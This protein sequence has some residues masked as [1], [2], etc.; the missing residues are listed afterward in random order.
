MSPS[1]LQ[2]VLLCIQSPVICLHVCCTLLANMDDYLILGEITVN[3]I[4]LADIVAKYL[5][6]L[7]KV[8]KGSVENEIKSP[9]SKIRKNCTETKSNCATAVNGKRR[10]SLKTVPT[11]SVLT[12][13]NGKPDIVHKGPNINKRNFRGET[14]LHTACIR[15]NV[16][17]VKELLKIPGVDVNVKDNA[18][19]TP[20]HEACN[21]GHVDCVRELLQFVP[22]KTVKE[23]FGTDSVKAHK[24][25]LLACTDE[26][27]TPLHDAVLNNRT[28]VCRLLLQHGG[29]R[30]AD[31]CYSMEVSTYSLHDAVLNNR[32]KVCRLLLQHGGSSLLECRTVRG[33]TPLDLAQTDELH[34]LLSSYQSTDHE[35]SLSCSQESTQSETPGEP[36]DFLYNHVLEEGTN[37]NYTSRQDTAK[38]IILVTTVIKSYLR[39]LDDQKSVTNTQN[40][41]ENLKPNQQTQSSPERCNMESENE[42][43]DKSVCRHKRDWKI[44]RKLRKY[45]VR[46]E[47]HIGRIAHP[48]DLPWLKQQLLSLYC[49]TERYTN[50]HRSV[51]AM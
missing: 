50:N 27:I 31:C 44:L 41:A 18:G 1:H 17:K 23:Y 15:N 6:L 25:D 37:R 33:F 4:T 10:L 12:E 20:L 47:N 28:E 16:N 42:I 30:S 7:P 19:W 29:L 3:D 34:E 38:Y 40:R 2:L 36:S 46:F 8:N 43:V 21:H 39:A 22:A 11:K 35:L 13:I 9:H 48:D 49:Y 24:V 14:A 32:T 45:V 26:L 51:S 5:Y